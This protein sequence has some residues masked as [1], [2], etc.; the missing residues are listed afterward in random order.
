MDLAASVIPENGSSPSS[1]PGRRL[2]FTSADSE[3][4]EWPQWSE[5]AKDP[6]LRLSH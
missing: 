1:A 3:L 5:A 6:D 4:I 2:P